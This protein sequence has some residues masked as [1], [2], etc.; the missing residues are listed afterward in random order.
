MKKEGLLN[1]KEWIHQQPSLSAK[2]LEQ[3]QRLFTE[4][5]KSLKAT[6]NLSVAKTRLQLRNLPKREFY[7]E[8]LRELLITVAKKYLESD[9]QPKHGQELPKAKSLIKQVKVLRD[10]E[11]TQVVDGEVLKL[12]SGLAFAEFADTKIA[13][14]AVRYLNN[15]RLTG[16][17]GLV[18]DFAIED[19]RKM[20]R[21]QQKLEAQS[22]KA[23]EAKKGYEVDNKKPFNVH[24]N[25]TYY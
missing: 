15:L 3:R 1:E 25:T 22:A 17:R 8:E 4:K 21:R 19:A 24:R 6:P 20:R 11:K 9:A 7:E 16:N 12:S 2:E 23:K 18:V 10:G 5:D 14:Y 13:L